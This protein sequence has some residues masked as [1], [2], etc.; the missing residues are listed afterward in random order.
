MGIIKGLSGCTC[1]DTL[2]PQSADVH[3]PKGKLKQIRE[4]L[5]GLLFVVLPLTGLSETDCRAAMLEAVNSG[6]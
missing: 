1:V 5:C 3:K 2:L 6:P 4:N